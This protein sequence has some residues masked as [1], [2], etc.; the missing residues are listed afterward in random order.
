[1]NIAEEHYDARQMKRLVQEQARANIFKKLAK[2]DKK[3]ERSKG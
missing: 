1:M 2:F 3:R